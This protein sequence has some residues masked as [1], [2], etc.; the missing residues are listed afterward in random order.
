VLSEALLTRPDFADSQRSIARLALDVP[1]DSLFDFLAPGVTSEDV[2]RLALVPFG[3]RRCVGVILEVTNTSAVVEEKLRAIERVMLDVPALSPTDLALFR[4]CAEYY[5]HPIGQVVLSALPP[6]LR[7]AKRSRLPGESWFRLTPA[8]RGLPAV[9]LAKRPLAQRR[10]FERLKMG[11][12]AEGELVAGLPRAGDALRRLIERGWIEHTAPPTRGFARP[13][14]LPYK[15]S[16]E[17][18]EAVAQI[19]DALGRYQPF[20]LHGVTASGKTEVYLHAVEHALALGRQVLVLVPEINLTPQLEHLFAARFPDAHIVSLHSQLAQTPRL[21]AWLDAQTL[22]AHVVLGTRLALFA[23][24]PKLGLIVVDEEQDPSFKQQ[25][26]LRYSARDMAVYRGKL[27]DCPVVLVSATPSLE[28]WYHSIQAP[29]QPSRYVPLLLSRRASALAVMPTMRLV[30][31]SQEQCIEGISKSLL[32]QLAIRLERGE[33]SL[34]FINRRGFSPALL[35]QQCAWMPECPH[36][37]ARL[38]FHKTDARLRC[39]HC[40]HQTRVPSH[41]GSCGSFD[42]APAGQGTQRIESFVERQFATARVARV[43]R[44]STRARGSAHR[45]FE[46]ARR[47][48]IDILIGTQLLAK[49]HDFANLTLVGVLNADAAMF[50]ADFRAPERLF[51]QLVQVAGRAGRAERA[52]EVLVQ[53][54]F[55]GHALYASVLTQDFARFASLQLEERRLSGMPPFSYL[56]LLRVEAKTAGLAQRFAAQAQELGRRLM[57][58]VSLFDAVPAPLQRKGGWERAQVLAQSKSRAAM[59]RFLTAWRPLLETTAP[60]AVRWVIDVDPLEV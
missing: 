12:L 15:L 36:C 3:K 14:A 7:A 54:R 51:A 42:L 20:L 9:D 26:G 4:F 5:H 41:C 16:A 46:S 45:L 28:S 29:R 24:L 10:V 47:G 13:S 1:V 34:L 25:E 56:A 44:D 58:G 33:Q 53:T 60:R 17:Q 59:R 27:A 6:A 19:R 32:D 18:R 38:V 21:R 8:G 43:D 48:E 49:G 23:P 2:G 57:A 40:G 55:P 22:R 37:S 11:S 50:S 30:D 31:E 52:G 35:C 39:H